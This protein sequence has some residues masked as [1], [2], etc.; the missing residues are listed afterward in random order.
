[1]K[2]LG[3]YLEEVRRGC[4]QHNVDYVQ[5]RTSRPL[6]AALAAF[7]SRRLGNQ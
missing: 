7:L 6:D 2:A 3:E 5:L 4:S 1:M